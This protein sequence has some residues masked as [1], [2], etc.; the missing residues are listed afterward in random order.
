[1][2]KVNNCALTSIGRL[3]FDFLYGGCNTFSFGIMLCFSREADQECH[4]YVV[5]GSA[6]C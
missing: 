4:S 6:S 3:D 1:M 2:S 5:K